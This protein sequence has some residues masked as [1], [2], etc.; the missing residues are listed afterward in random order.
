MI[1]AR[2]CFI[3]L[4]TTTQRFRLVQLPALPR[5]QQEHE[6]ARRGAVRGGHEECVQVKEQQGTKV[7][8]QQNGG[9]VH[10]L[11]QALAYQ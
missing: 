6:E 8:L 5:V 3:Q 2:T 9:L 4:T 1:L 7:I 11:R 10:L